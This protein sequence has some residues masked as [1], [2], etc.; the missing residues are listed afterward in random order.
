MGL[1][2]LFSEKLGS[3]VVIVSV[4]GEADPKVHF[5]F[6]YTFLVLRMERELL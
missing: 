2:R 4:V 5:G 1:N 3:F 6:R